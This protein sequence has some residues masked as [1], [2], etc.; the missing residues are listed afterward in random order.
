MHIHL[1]GV[2][3]GNVRWDLI[4]GDDNPLA[5]RGA[6]RNEEAGRDPKSRTDE[7]LWPRS[8][9]RI[10]S[11][12]FAALTRNHC[13]PLTSAEP[14]RDGSVSSLRP[15]ASILLET[16]RDTRLETHLL[17][18]ALELIVPERIT[19]LTS[20]IVGVKS[21]QEKFLDQH[22]ELA[23]R[24]CEGRVFCFHDP[25]FSGRFEARDGMASTKTSFKLP[26]PRVPK[27]AREGSP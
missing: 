18:G 24:H 21:S 20:T 11:R 27:R 15:V 1:E 6:R 14:T 25:T 19:H 8:A 9:L 5:E 4:E 3:R 2:P 16:Y 10:R 22:P 23:L 13:S 7:G 17:L 26:V 12:D